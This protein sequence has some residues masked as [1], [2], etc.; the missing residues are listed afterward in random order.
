MS[1]SGR[2]AL[3]CPALAPRDGGR[4]EFREVAGGRCQPFEFG[5]QVPHRF[6]QPQHQGDQ[7]VARQVAQ[8]VRIWQRHGANHN[9]RSHSELRAPLS[10]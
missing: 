1:V 9:S 8:A 4:D 2:P 10:A 3:V 7:L 6:G 5:L